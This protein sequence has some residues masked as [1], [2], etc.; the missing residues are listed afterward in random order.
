MALVCRK[1]CRGCVGN[2]GVGNQSGGFAHFFGFFQN[3]FGAV[4]VF[5]RTNH[6]GA[7]GLAGCQLRGGGG[8]I[9]H[10]IV[11]GVGHGK[12]HAA[13]G[14]DPIKGGVAIGDHRVW[15]LFGVR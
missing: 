10:Q 13:V 15:R 6:L 1:A 3:A 9:Y 11:V 7:G 12:S 14:G 4:A 5:V 2:A 8:G